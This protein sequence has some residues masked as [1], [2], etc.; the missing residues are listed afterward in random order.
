MMSDYMKLQAS[1]NQMLHRMETFLKVIE[2]QKDNEIKILN[3]EKIP[4][5]Q[6]IN[7]LEARAK[8]AEAQ[9]KIEK[10]KTKVKKYGCVFPE[11]HLTSSHKNE[12]IEELQELI[13]STFET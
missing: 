12:G 8:G 7:N 4:L 5:Q 3:R 6:R 10:T 11:P 9:I 1:S 2:N 13:V